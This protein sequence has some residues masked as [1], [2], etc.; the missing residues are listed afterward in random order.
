M[1]GNDNGIIG[2]QNLGLAVC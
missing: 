2:R 1:I